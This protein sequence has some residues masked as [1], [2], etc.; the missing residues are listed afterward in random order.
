MT[1]LRNIF[2][3]NVIEKNGKEELLFTLSKMM[4]ERRM[5]SHILF[6][7]YHF[8][9]QKEHCTSRQQSSS[10]ERL[11]PLEHVETMHKE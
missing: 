1:I 3:S 7:V 11:T 5:V 2:K 9:V 10:C 6:E 8:Q 4:D